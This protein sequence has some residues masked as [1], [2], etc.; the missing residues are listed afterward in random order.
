MG[1]CV[2]TPWG[3]GAC[4]STSATHTHTHTV[5]SS[6]KNAE[7][8]RGGLGR[9]PRIQVPGSFLPPPGSMAQSWAVHP[10]LSLVSL[11]LQAL[12]ILS[13]VYPSTWMWDRG[14][15]KGQGN[16]SKKTWQE[17]I[18]DTFESIMVNI[19]KYF[20]ISFLFNFYIVLIIGITNILFRKKG[21]IVTI[22]PWWNVRLGVANPCG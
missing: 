16:S 12:R 1:K 10:S 3:G 14:A 21:F 8:G 2:L 6:P 9:K 13:K 18:S 17:L 15:W 11:P 22:F 7:V 20:L 5:S 4:M 19:L